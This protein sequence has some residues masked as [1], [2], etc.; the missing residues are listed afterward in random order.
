MVVVALYDNLLDLAL[1]EPNTI[2][3]WV[4]IRSLPPAPLKLEKVASSVRATLG[5]VLFVDQLGVVPVLSAIW[6]RIDLAGSS[7]IWKQR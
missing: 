3:V 7:V 1:V 5:L 6:V 4:Q 2:K